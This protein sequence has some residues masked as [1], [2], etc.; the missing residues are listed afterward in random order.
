M[1]LVVFGEKVD[2]LNIPSPEPGGF[3][4]A[5]DLDGILKQKD[6]NGIISIIGGGNN[7]L[8][9][10][11]SL[12]NNTGINSIVLDSS[13]ISGTN[14]ISL[15]NSL[16]SLTTDNG[17]YGESYLFMNSES[18]LLS[19]GSKGFRVEKDI[20]DNYNVTTRY[21]VHNEQIIKENSYKLNLNDKPVLEFTIGTTSTIGGSRLSSL[22]SSDGSIINPG[23]INTVVLGGFGINALQSNSVY[24]PD[25]YIQDGKLIKGTNGSAKIQFTQYNDII[26]SNDNSVFGILS[27]T[28]STVLNSNGILLRDTLI[29]TSTP[30]IDAG[31]S[32][33]STKNSNTSSG[34][35]N[36]VVLGGEGLSVTE[37]NTVYLGNTVNINNQYKLPNVDGSNGQVLKTDGSGNTYWDYTILTL[38]TISLTAIEFQSLNGV[39]DTDT[40]YIITDADINLY[41][42][43][44]IYLTTNTYGI[45]NDTGIGK[46]YN[47]LYNQLTTGFGIWNISNTYLI[48]DI[49]IWGGYYWNNTTGL[50][51]SAIDIYTLSSDWTKE[52]YLPYY[53]TS[54]D[55]IK[56]D[57]INDLITYR[58]EE[59]TNIVST[60]KADIIYWSTIDTLYN[61]IKS[62]QW[63]NIYDFVTDK[64][65]GSQNIDNS[66]NQNINFT[67]AKQT[68]ITFNNKSYQI[69]SIFESDSYQNNIIFNN[70]HQDGVNFSNSSYQEGLNF[71]NSNQ[72]QLTESTGLSQVNLVFENNESNRISTPL[73]LSENGLFI[74]SDVTIDGKLTVF[75]TASIIN[76]EN[77]LVQDP[78]ILLSG[79]QSGIPTLDSG[80]FINRGTSVTEAFI[81]DE[82][83]SEFSFISTNDNSTVIGDV[84]IVDY[85]NIHA[86][87]AIMT[88]TVSST[89]F[90]LFSGTSLQFLKGDGSVD[91][92]TYTPTGRTITIN[93]TSYDLSANRTWDVGT[94]TGTGTT[95]YIPKYIGSTI[96]GNSLIYDNGSSLLI[97]TTT[98]STIDSSTQLSI[99]KGNYSTLEVRADTESKILLSTDVNGSSPYIEIFNSYGHFGIKQIPD[100]NSTSTFLMY[101][102]ENGTYFQTNTQ[103]RLSISNTGQSVFSS[104]VTANSFIKSGG[105][106]SQ[107]L[108]AD[109]SVDS[110]V[111]AID[112]NVVHKTGDET[113]AGLKTFTDT[114]KSNVTSGNIFEIYDGLNINGRISKNGYDGIDIFNTIDKSGYGIVLDGNDSQFVGIYANNSHMPK[115]Y[116]D[117]DSNVSQQPLHSVSFIKSGGTSSQ[118][119][120]ADGSVDSNVYAIDS[121]V[122]H[123]TGTESI[124]GIKTFNDII[125]GATVSIGTTFR[126]QD[127][128]QGN[129]Y[130]LTSDANGVG[131]WTSSIHTPTYK[132]YSALISQSGTSA[133]T[134]TILEN[135]L[136]NVV[137]SRSN[138]G[139]YYGTLSSAFT[140][141]KTFIQISNVTAL[142]NIFLNYNST[143]DV[144]LQTRNS[145]N[146]NIDSSLTNNSVEIRVYY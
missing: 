49:S 7:P 3:L 19:N 24:V 42:G 132:V 93:G 95:G 110:N 127:G 28:S 141:G 21:D 5:Y 43:T 48:S 139:T 17:L 23:I 2:M 98:Q 97:G 69:N 68:N 37:S 106:S 1:A 9:D 129:G 123:K 145:S 131:S 113:I 74:G 134:V 26:S 33:I 35:A 89:A 100:T 63:G 103:T 86:N 58:N 47:P 146:V 20:Y 11:L 118:F 92:N 57:W 79:T 18:L 115:F 12:G 4:I 65:I 122:V 90:K 138:V 14:R 130:V 66:Y 72:T 51:G 59:N 81:W 38:N 121:N 112:S 140:S 96:L 80:I 64:G 36:S 102:D 73:T 13:I 109:G 101:N 77:L 67:G 104:T 40:T 46:F 78:I 119:L 60:N 71:L 128:T 76:S 135:T 50:A 75:G 88:G 111:Y 15:D 8:S 29:S 53:E 120:K 91:T 41:G 107:F 116:V 56:Y 144:Q 108:K 44:E 62:F 27:S 45:L 82:S 39:F 105:T 55:I 54:Y 94:L 137:W 70:S 83:M 85:S 61:P 136:G 10:V 25:L 34:I 114:I 31:V 22:L 84:N 124:S 143:N 99:Y 16:V 142:V 32:Y 52:T 117:S 126:L 133:P 6:E 125:Y 30:N 87:N